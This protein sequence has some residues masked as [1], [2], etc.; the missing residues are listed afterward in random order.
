MSEIQ[1]KNA[2]NGNKIMFEITKCLRLL[3][4]RIEHIESLT[5]SSV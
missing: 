3:F 2:A 4:K 5:P 1:V